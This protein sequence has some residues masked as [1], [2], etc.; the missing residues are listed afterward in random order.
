M[1]WY[2]SGL[3]VNKGPPATIFA[4]NILHLCITSLAES[5]CMDIALIKIKSAQRMSSSINLFVFISIILLYQSLGSIAA[6]V[7]S[8]NGG[9]LAFYATNF[10]ACLKL[11]NVSGY[12]G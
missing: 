2:F 3:L 6:T 5:L 1:F 12:F 10:K 7:N 4:F 9:E 11:Q 8:P